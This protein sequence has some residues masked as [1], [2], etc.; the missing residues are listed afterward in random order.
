MS[1]VPPFRI[2]CAPYLDDLTPLGSAT[3]SQL[4][5]F[6]YKLRE[7]SPTE[8]RKHS[9]KGSSGNRVDRPD[10]FRRGDLQGGVV[11]VQ[12]VRRRTAKVR[13]VARL[14]RSRVMRVTHPPRR[15]R[16]MRREVQL[17]WLLVMA[18]WGTVRP[19]SRNVASGSRRVTAF[20][21]RVTRPGLS[22][23]PSREGVCSGDL[24][25]GRER[26]DVCWLRHRGNRQIQV[27]SP[28]RQCVSSSRQ[29]V[30][31]TVEVAASPAQAGRGQG[32]GQPAR[33]EVAAHE[34]QV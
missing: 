2:E 10:D 31:F 12:R 24:L 8:S 16:A 6:N 28:L 26:W 5:N 27:V 18:L 17:L 4:E 14:V 23:T 34:L 13:D 19:V 25:V 33:L 3:I 22:V 15:V 11:R 20:A 32:Q 30:S 9:R 29:G 1:S 7:N 21:P